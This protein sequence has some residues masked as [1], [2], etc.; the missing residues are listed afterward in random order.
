MVIM[1][2]LAVFMLVSI[3]F[4]SSAE[5]NNDA[6]RKESPLYVIRTRRAI[7]ENIE[8]I[9]ENIKTKLFGERAFFLP[10]QSMGDS[11][12]VFDK[13]GLFFTRAILACTVMC[14]RP[15]YICII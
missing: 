14:Y 1:G 10:F 9:V 3:S 15:S 2:L 8:K 7:S 4:V 13:G 11:K 5:V 6:E 12:P